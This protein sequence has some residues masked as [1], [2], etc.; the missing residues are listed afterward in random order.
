MR[1]KD[2][3]TSFEDAVDILRGCPFVTVIFHDEPYP[4][5][6]PMH[7]G[8]A[9]E[10]GMPVLYFHGA[11]EGR[12]HSLLAMDAHVAFSGV[13]FCRDIPPAGGVAC[14]AAAEFESVFGEGEM[15][16]VKGS[17]AERG[18]RLLLAHSG[19]SGELS[20]AAVSRVCVLRLTVQGLT[21]KR[22]TN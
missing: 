18:L 5:A 14:T 10:G 21:G 3:E 4:Y 6:V 7:F 12:K 2:R 8:M 13:R 22:R 17:E 16:A 1:R 9:S 20:A 11:R 15:R 19:M